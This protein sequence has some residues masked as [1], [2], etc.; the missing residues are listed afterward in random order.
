MILH[1]LADINQTFSFGI[2]STQVY[3]S[4]NPPL[5]QDSG[6]IYI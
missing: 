2:H 5:Q 6:R 1:I 4:L 3:K